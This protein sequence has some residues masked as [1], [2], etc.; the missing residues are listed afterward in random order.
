[1]KMVVR[2][3]DLKSHRAELIRFLHENHTAD[4]DSD[5]FDRSYLQNPSGHARAWVAND[6]RRFTSPSPE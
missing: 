3:A 4:S 2:E 1:M 5:R 6:T